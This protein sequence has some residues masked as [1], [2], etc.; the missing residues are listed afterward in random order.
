MYVRNLLLKACFYPFSTTGVCNLGVYCHVWIFV[1]DGPYLSCFATCASECVGNK[2]GTVYTAQKSHMH[3]CKAA[4]NVP[5]APRFH[6][7]LQLF[8]SS[9]HTLK[10]SISSSRTE[11]CF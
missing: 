4:Q 6:N 9:N 8:L 2:K 5:K 7:I 10:I 1:V 11:G 3:N